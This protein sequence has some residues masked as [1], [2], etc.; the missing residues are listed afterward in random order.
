MSTTPLHVNLV[1]SWDTPCGIAEHSAYLKES[2]EAADPGIKI[3][4][5]AENLDP[6][7]FLARVDNGLYMDPDGSKILHL[8]YHA[9]L[10]SQ[11]TTERIEQVKDLGWKVLITYHDTFEHNPEDVW[12]K[13]R[14]ADAVVVHEPCDLTGHVGGL[15][16]VHYW[17][18]GVPAPADVVYRYASRADT[19]V[20]VPL[21]LSAG[22]GLIAFKAYPQQPVV[23][24]VGFP[25]PWKN[26][27]LLCQAA[28][29][30]GWAVV[31]LAPTA[32]EDDVKR[33]QGLNPDTLVITDFLPRQQVTRYLAGCHTTAF[34]Y[35]CANS[36]TSGAIRLGLAA[37]RPILALG[38]CR[39]FRD[40][41]ELD[42]ESSGIVWLYDGSVSGVANALA[43]SLSWGRGNIVRQAHEDSWAKLGQKYAALYRS[44]ADNHD[45]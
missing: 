41:E 42:G 12:Q 38:G 2:V 37:R 29:L 18:Q 10:H 13:V 19:R 15:K 14:A 17:R 27:D 24:T 26:Y 31:L 39:Q 1:T 5:D 34:L 35:N 23:G 40:L 8:N 43:S 25:F 6:A 45:A 33:W 9:A 3:H 44:L 20:V 28:E 32:T 4:P 36:G 7:I 16:R 22:G 21:N 30:A 11:W